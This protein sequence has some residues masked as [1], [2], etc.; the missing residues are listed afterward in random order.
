MRAG[1]PLAIRVAKPAD[2][3]AVGRLNEELGY[4]SS[5][6][7]AARRLTPLLRSRNDTVLVAARGRKVIGWL[8]VAHVPSLESGPSAE[9]RGLVVT[10]N[11]RSRGIGARLVAAAEEWAARRGLAKMRVR[12]NVLRTDARR[13]YQRLG[14]AVTKTQNV[15]D[16]KLGASEPQ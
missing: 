1:R 4:R 15:F 8:H 10:A 16:K 13:F 5:G 2:A 3:P 12:S 6:R 11:E 7:E 9:I 14:Y